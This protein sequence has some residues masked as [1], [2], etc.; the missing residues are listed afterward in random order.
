MSTLFCRNVDLKKQFLYYHR[1]DYRFETVLNILESLGY[2]IIAP[3]VPFGYLWNEDMMFNSEE[4]EKFAI[5]RS[6]IQHQKLL[7]LV[8]WINQD[9]VCRMAQIVS[10]F[11]DRLET[12][13]GQCDYCLKTSIT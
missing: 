1:R 13:C 12:D 7:D 3:E 4:F 6:H 10:Y 8:N 9:Q 2:L 5:D 11:G